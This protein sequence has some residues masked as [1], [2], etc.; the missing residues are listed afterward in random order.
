ME[1]MGK[2]FH[3]WG[4]LSLK[5]RSISRTKFESAQNGSLGIY[6]D[7]GKVD[8]MKNILPFLIFDQTFS[9]SLSAL[10]GHRGG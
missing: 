10:L 2:I 3:R 9:K 8:T 4:F 6:S 7:G 5:N 1:K